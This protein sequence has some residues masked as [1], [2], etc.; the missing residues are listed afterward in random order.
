V[1]GEELWTESR[2]EHWLTAAWAEGACKALA[3]LNPDAGEFALEAGGPQPESWRAWVDSVWIVFPCDIAPAAGISVGCSREVLQKL[4]ALALG[5]PEDAD[6]LA[7]ETFRELIS[8]AVASLGAALNSQS[9]GQARFAGG[10]DVSEPSDASLGV[11][12][13]FEIGGEKTSIALA[14]NAAFLEAA[15]GE[16]AGE[17]TAV[18]TEPESP[19]EETP[20]DDRGGGARRNLEILLDLEMEVAVS[21][22]QTEML[23]KDVLKLSVGSIV[24]LECQAS[25][26][27]EVLVN[28]TVIARGEVVV[29]DSNYGVRITDVS[30]RRERIQSIF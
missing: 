29:V 18:E 26:P 16:A 19:V 6:G 7:A 22:G 13:G 8:Q 12:G 23:L 9:G 4:G 28:D 21:F 24:E 17:E 25:D 15:L 27:V 20:A 1:S 14:P 11:E 10:V 3:L 2:T 30:S 5:D